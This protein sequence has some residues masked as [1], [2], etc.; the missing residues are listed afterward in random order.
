MGEQTVRRTGYVLT[1]VSVV[2]W[3]ATFLI[4]SGVRDSYFMDKPAL[5]AALGRV[6]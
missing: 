6:R 4:K 3:L 5:T 1:L 2:G